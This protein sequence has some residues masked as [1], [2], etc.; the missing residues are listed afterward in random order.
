MMLHV[1][2]FRNVLDVSCVAT[3][4]RFASSRLRSTMCWTFHVSGRT[5]LSYPVILCSTDSYF[6]VQSDP[7]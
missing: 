4:K 3:T 6:G 5:T 2:C 7:F 1:T